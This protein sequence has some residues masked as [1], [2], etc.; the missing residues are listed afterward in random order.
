M[1]KLP[2]IPTPL[3]TQWREFRIQYL[4]MITFVALIILVA[5]MWREY[6]AP[7]NVV[8]VAEPISGRVMSSLPGVLISLDVQRYQKVTNGQVIGVVRTMDTNLLESSMA[9]IRTDLELNRARFQMDND[10]NWQTYNR[11]L[12]DFNRDKVQLELDRVNVMK[13]LAE[14]LRVSNLFNAKPAALASQSEYDLAKYTY[15]TY[16]VTVSETEKRLAEEAKILPQMVGTNA[17]L[18]QAI[19][20]SMEAQLDE[21]LASQRVVLRAPITGTVSSIS[22]NVGEAVLAARPVVTITADESTN[23]MA[24]ARQPLNVYPKPGDVVQVRRQT[25]KREVDY[26]QITQVGVVLE[27]IDRPL[28]GSSTVKFG[29]DLALPFTVSVPKGL[30]LTPGERVDVIFSPRQKPVLN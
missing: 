2:P 12:L 25:F 4:P 27:L 7:P 29:Y 28:L 3:E 13:T 17:S 8:A 11:A 5:S 10:R 18:A 24:Y 26:G 23:I 16:R 22:N 21:L 19:V 30:K 14:F 9:A 15:E 1:Q 20:R 6:V